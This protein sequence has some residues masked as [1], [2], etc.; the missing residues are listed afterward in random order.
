MTLVSLL[1]LPLFFV[2]FIVAFVRSDLLPQGVHPID[3]EYFVSEVIKC[4]DG[5]KSFTRDRLNDNYCDCV[6]GT[7]EPGTAACPGGKFYCRNAGSVPN[8]IFSS[9]VNDDFCDCCDGSDEYE[10]RIRCPNTCIMG[11]TV[12]HKSESIGISVHKD[13]EIDN[14]DV[15]ETK[16]GVNLKELVQTLEGLTFVIFLQMSAVGF[17]MVLWVSEKHDRSRKR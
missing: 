9:R 16:N 6:D 2:I 4:R 13:L 10:N 8:F 5:S 15:K 11:G 12:E 7:D 3:E 1:D 14:V 17:L